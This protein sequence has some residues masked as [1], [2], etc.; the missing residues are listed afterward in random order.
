ELAGG[1]FAPLSGPAIAGC[2]CLPLMRFAETDAIG[3]R[4]Q[5]ADVFYRG[6]AAGA[7]LISVAC[8]S[9][10]DR[11]KWLRLINKVRTNRMPHATSAPRRRHVGS[12]RSRRPR[13]PPGTA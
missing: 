6:E 5:Q 8:L 1:R 12:A 4:R 13:R 7:K 11:D 10:E 3:E 9:Q 2:A